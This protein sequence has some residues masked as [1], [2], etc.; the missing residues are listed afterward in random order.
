[1][2]FVSAVLM[3]AIRNQGPDP[4]SLMLSSA[5]HDGLEFKVMQSVIINSSSLVESLHQQ[6][7]FCGSRQ[8][9]C[10]HW[11]LAKMARQLGMSL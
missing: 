8:H 2:V 9:L 4:S 7:I 11:F 5:E 3:V 6:P 1:M 10:Y